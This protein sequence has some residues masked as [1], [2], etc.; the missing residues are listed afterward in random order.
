LKTRLH[1]KIDCIIFVKIKNV[2]KITPYKDSAL[3]KRTG[4]KMFDAISVYLNRVISFGIDI[5]WRKKSVEI[6]AKSNQIHF[7]Y[8]NRTGDLAI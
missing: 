6:V 5:K 1:F 7:R 4:C 8:R 2:K 3:G